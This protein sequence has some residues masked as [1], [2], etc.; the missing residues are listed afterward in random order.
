MTSDIETPVFVSIDL[1]ERSPR[2]YRLW[3]SALLVANVVAEVLLVAALVS[4]AATL[5]VI[6][7]AVGAAVVAIGTVIAAVME[8]LRYRGAGASTFNGIMA[9]IGNP[10]LV[11]GAL[12]NLGVLDFG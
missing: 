4:D 7:A 1:R 9:V 6:G 5:I 3:S 12:V 2:W 10:Y 11:L 8:G